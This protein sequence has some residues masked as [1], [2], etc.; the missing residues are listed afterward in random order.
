MEKKRVDYLDMVK[1]IGIILV[2]IGHS[3]YLAYHG[4][5]V[6]SSFHMPLFFIV[7]GMLIRHTG[8]EQREMK[9][10][11]LRKL[12]SI[13]IPYVVFC[14]IYLAIYGGYFCRVAG[15]LTPEYIQEI[16]VQ[17]ISLDGISVL[18]F[19]SALF[20][21]QMLFLGLRRVCKKGIF[22]FIIATMA[23]TACVIKP[24]VFGWL[25]AKSLWQKGLV[26]VLYAIFRSLAGAGFLLIGYLT[27]ELF[28]YLDDTYRIKRTKLPELAGG[29][30]CLILTIILS[31]YNGRVDLH[32]MEFGNLFLYLI[33]AYAG[34][35][36]L[37]LICRNVPHQRWLAYLGINS[38]II[39]VTHLDCQYM[40]LSIR[41]GQFFVALSPYAKWYCLYFGI[42]L[43]MTVLELV[44]IYVVNHWLPF[45]I[46]K[47]YRH[48]NTKREMAG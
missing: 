1:G 14:L 33:C 13:M 38:L 44:T 25:V 15:Y 22:I 18:W 7:S 30:A 4:L 10:I 35:M 42:A 34:A 21:A 39:M 40:L 27:M 23:I 43:G 32:Y 37:I 24:Y 46:G 48:K 5:T 9:Q 3:D 20:L 45:L 19:L 31:I 12:K 17:A 26:G 36:G 16:A 28:E 6:I 41:V 47:K 8:E 2:V 29:S 11:F